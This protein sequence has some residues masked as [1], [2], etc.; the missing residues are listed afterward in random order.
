M[1]LKVLRR[2]Y[3]NDSTTGMMFIDDVEFCYTLEDR[4][5]PPD[6]KVPG[7][8]CIPAGRYRVILDWS[9]RFKRV[10]PHILDVPG[11]IGIR[12]HMG[13]K[14][15]DTNGCVLVGFR[16]S[17]DVLDFIGDSKKAFNAL[18]AILEKAEANKEKVRLTIS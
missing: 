3:T 17:P 9:N 10:M 6:V 12:I 8:T 14:A 5:R 4:L 16:Q 15:V 18:F 11:Y 2:I 1:E 7:S 13:N